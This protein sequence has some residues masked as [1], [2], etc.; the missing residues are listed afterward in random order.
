MQTDATCLA[1]QCC[2]RLHGPLSDRFSDGPFIRSIF[3][4][5]LTRINTVFKI[6][7]FFRTY[8]W[9]KINPKPL[10]FKIWS[11]FSIN[12]VP[13]KNAKSIPSFCSVS[14]RVNFARYGPRQ[15]SWRN[16]YCCGHSQLTF[17]DKSGRYYRTKSQMFGIYMNA[18]TLGYRLG[19]LKVIPP[20]CSAQLFCAWR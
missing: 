9:T 1:Q 17:E 5:P 7:H 13:L 20:F 15:R 10:F 2:V 14:R 19:I 18:W 8:S 6:A 12:V 3:R 16:M 11:S 4:R